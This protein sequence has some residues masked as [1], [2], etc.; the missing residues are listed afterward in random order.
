MSRK[1]K[2]TVFVGMSGG[3]DSS[4]AALLLKKEGYSVVGIF[5]RNWHEDLHNGFGEC[6][7][8]KDLS[9]VRRVCAMLDIPYYVWDFSKEYYEDVVEYFFREY[10]AGRTPNPDVMCNK[11]I[12]FGR[13]FDRAI[14]LGADFVAT[15]HYARVKE[16]RG[17]Y[18]LLKAKDKNKDQTYFLWTITQKQLSRT[19]FP[20]GEYTK[21][22]I[23][24]IA[25]KEGLPTAE[26]PDSQGICFIGR[27]DVRDFIKT[28]L[29]EKEGDIV[30]VDGKV[31]GRHKGVWFYTEG[32]RHGLNIGGSGLPY[33]VVGKDVEKNILVVA[34]GPQHD[35]LYRKKLYA[36]SLN[37]VSGKEPKYPFM[38]EARI[39]YRQPLQKCTIVNIKDERAEV[40]FEEKQRAIAPGQ[41]IVFYKG[42]ECIGGGVIICK[43]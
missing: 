28:R 30:T 17:V 7:W 41:S 31:V 21:P 25:K 23:R 10:K 38:C 11:Y 43:S 32:Q 22:Q 29:K 37:W 27:V 34:L 24:R 8:E 9:D 18:R 16:S 15:G 3:V 40:V 36:D 39:R 14:K 2:K 20:I 26:K 19:L 33:Y 42:R 12:K 5:M 1:K 4:V 6:T 35:A 13:F